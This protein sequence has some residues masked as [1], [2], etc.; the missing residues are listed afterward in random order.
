ML[1]STVLKHH[2]IRTASVSEPDLEPPGPA[3]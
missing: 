3:R 1:A 2:V